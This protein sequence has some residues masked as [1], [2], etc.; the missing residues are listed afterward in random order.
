MASAVSL[1]RCPA[2]RA[3]DVIQACCACVRLCVPLGTTTRTPLLGNYDV[4]VLEIALRELGKVRWWLGTGAGHNRSREGCGCGE[5]CASWGKG[6]GAWQGGGLA[7]ERR[8]G[9]GGCRGAAGTGMRWRS[10]PIRP[11]ELCRMVCLPSFDADGASAFPVFLVTARR[12]SQGALASPLNR[13]SDGR[14]LICTGYLRLLAP[15]PVS[16]TS[17][18][19]RS[20]FHQGAWG[21][22]IDHAYLG[23]HVTPLPAPA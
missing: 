19:F 2:S 4:H 6:T 17:I 23:R 22:A 20:P 7:Q 15:C 5:G 1:T 9:R 18:P 16:L 13:G 8:T 10:G 21:V 11:P 14:Y 3:C 12:G